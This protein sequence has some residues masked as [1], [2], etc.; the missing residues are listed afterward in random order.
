MPIGIPATL[1]EISDYY[2]KKQ[3]K[4]VDQ[5]TEET[6]VLQRIKFEEA[7]HALWNSYEE[8]TEIEGAG[9]VEMNSPLPKLGFAT[10]LKKINLNIFGG[11]MECPEDTAQMFGGKEKYFARKMPKVLRESGMSAEKTIIY[12]NL[13]KWATD[14]ENPGKAYDVGGT[15]AATG[16]TGL[17]SII[18]LRQL[19][20][21]NCGL[22][23]PEGFKHGAM[24]DTLPINGG[25]IYK[26]DDGVL[27]YGL[28]LKA[29]F[30]Y[31]IANSR[32]VGALVNINVSNL[33]APEV[34]DDLLA[35]VRAT[36]ASTLLLMHPRLLNW[37][38]AYK[39]EKLQVEV[40]TK[41]IDRRFTHWNGVEIVTTYN[42]TDGNDKQYTVV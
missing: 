37:L 33:P 23:S 7:S 32:A 8:A 31:Q 20:G 3:P 29:Y 9:L 41:D 27:T 34:I 18:A 6:P 40:G 5:L 19:P 12:E 16:N 22:Y 11:I 30:G 25:N 17:Y 14:E 4:Q 24:F 13:L 10:E 35:D 36:P 42:F 39:A 2:A 28:R 1:K 26:N 21:E 38:N 15:K